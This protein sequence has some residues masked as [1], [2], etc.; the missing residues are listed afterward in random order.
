MQRPSGAAKT[1]TRVRPGTELTTDVGDVAIFPSGNVSDT[2]AVDQGA[3][4][5]IFETVTQGGNPRGPIAQSRHGFPPC[6]DRADVPFVVRTPRVHPSGRVLLMLVLCMVIALVLLRAA[7]T[8]RANM[9]RSEVSR[10]HCNI[11]GWP[12]QRSN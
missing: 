7:L 10:S 9:L 6:R 11:H 5:V 12:M 8:A 4:M 3:T 2:R 1:L